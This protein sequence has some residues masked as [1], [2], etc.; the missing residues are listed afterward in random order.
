MSSLPSLAL[1]DAD[2]TTT[3]HTMTPPRSFT[4][5]SGRLTARTVLAAPHTVV[6]ARATYTP[7]ERPPV[8]WD[9]TIA[10]R[11]LL[12]SHGLGV[13][14]AMDTSERGP[15]GLRWPQAQE[16]IERSLA[17]AVQHDGL[18]LCGAGTDQLD[19][20]APSLAAVTEA[21]LEQ[22]EFVQSRGG[23]AI[24]RASHALHRIARSTDDY[25]EVY[26]AV[27]DAVTE[28]AVVHWLGDVFDPD[29][30]GYWGTTDLDETA[31]I[32][33]ALAERHA[34][35]LRGIKVSILNEA[36]EVAFRRGLPE[37][38]HVLTGDDH[39]YPALLAGDGTHHSDGLLGIFTSLAPIASTALQSLESGDAATFRTE[40]DATLPLAETMFEA[41]AGSYKTGVV[42]LAWLGGY[43]DAFRMVSGREGARSLQHLAQLFAHTDRLGLFTDPELTAHR[44]RH[45][46]ETSGVQQTSFARAS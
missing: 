45:F 3:L 25:L 37:G 43:Q 12:W 33:T 30:R 31:R 6:D 14:E 28:P 36:R 40:L 1:P 10:Y 16:L 17:A 24:V 44:M 34:P 23:G 4:R 35:R 9:A 2:G 13:A 5:P 26:D 21:Y 42:F 27:L 22:L 20:P 46:L 8:D 18:V 29:L 38:V 39:N 41:P 11:E 7:G 19:H 15:W 32:L